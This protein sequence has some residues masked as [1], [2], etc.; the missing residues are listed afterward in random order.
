MRSSTY[1][2]LEYENQNKLKVKKDENAAS[3][4]VDLNLN[5]DDKI[6]LE[7]LNEFNNYNENKYIDN[8]NNNDIKISK[9][10]DSDNKRSI[11][12][13]NNNK[14]SD[15]DLQTG[16]L[17]IDIPPLDCEMIWTI[18]AIKRH[19]MLSRIICDWLELLVV[20]EYL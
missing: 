5:L 3:I 10:G 20:C 12:I 8:K 2:E 7:K 16:I 6:E 18:G 19:K 14:K 4:I 1:F 17:K 11:K 13:S 9:N 15:I